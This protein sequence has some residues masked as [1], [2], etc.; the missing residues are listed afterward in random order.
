LKTQ[1]SISLAA[2]LLLLS[3]GPA[4][5][6]QAAP[7]DQTL[8]PVYLANTDSP[9]EG[10]EQAPQLDP[11]ASEPS[12]T[13]T[14]T[15][16]PSNGPMLNLA[17]SK[18][19]IPVQRVGSFATVITK[20]Q[21]RQMQANSIVDVLKRVPGID[22]VQSGGLGQTT[23]IFMRGMNS[24]HTMVLVDGIEVNDPSAPGRTF[25]F[26]DQ[27]GIDSVD[28]IEVLRGPQSQLYGSDALAGVINIITDVGADKQ[29]AYIRTQGG[30]YGTVQGDVDYRGNVLENK[31]RYTFHAMQQRTSGFSAAS[32]RYGNNE[33]D[34]FKNTALTGRV[35]LQPLPNFSVNLLTN[36][37]NSKTALDDHGGVDGDNPH[38]T[39]RNK[40]L[41]LGGRSRLSL[42]NNR[43]EQITRFSVSDSNRQSS[44]NN[45][46]P[47]KLNA[48]DYSLSRYHGQMMKID[49]QNNFRL[50]EMNKLTAGAEVTNE[51]AKIDYA[52]RFNL[53]DYSTLPPTPI[54]DANGNPMVA[55]Y[56]SNLK[57]R[58]ATNV[59]LYVQDYIQHNER[60]FTTIGARW[61]EYNRFGH[62]TTYRGASTYLIPETGTTLRTS[63]GTGFKAPTLYELYDPFV[64]N[65]K[66]KAEK[67]KGWDFNLEQKLFKDSLLIGATYFHN[68]VNNMIQGVPANN[69]LYT[70][71]G[72][73]RMV[74]SEVYSSW[75]PRRWL[76]ARGSY[77]AAY[78]RDLDN[79]EQLL[80]R[81]THKMSFNINI[82]P[83]A[84]LNFNVDITH[85]GNSMDQI[86]NSVTNSPVRVVLN[87]YTLLNIAVNYKLSKNCTLFG[88]VVNLLDTPYESVKGYGNPRISAYGGLQLGI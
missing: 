25:N 58:T 33:R 45:Y 65:A 62:A 81:P 2:S 8:E 83:T 44:S 31:I 80:R 16:S 1:V 69:Y 85:I 41:F 64:G 24:E 5:A 71:I 84:K 27:I 67:S 19:G 75:T 35:A 38:F 21:I 17:T 48:G 77:T 4:M 57:R 39:T 43:F 55:S 50:N 18:I 49:V 13:P 56:T 34:G 11:A 26:P 79:H 15:N 87:N 53:L 36:Y 52:S 51:L 76:T 74:G 23:S 22:V 20:D 46:I 82:Q 66:L 47:A 7:S 37:A 72:N 68:Y 30:S 10:I 73:A 28:R 63:Y 78:A 14:Y 3:A 61:D 60:W 70:N 9:T 54:L 59:G 12:A 88:R 29:T 42:F 40:T 6:G 32:S 86:Y